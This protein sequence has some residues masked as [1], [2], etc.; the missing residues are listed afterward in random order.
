MNDESLRESIRRENAMLRESAHGGLLRR[1]GSGARLPVDTTRDEGGESWLMTYLDLMTL[2]LVLF[3][4][5]LAYAD[6]GGE[7]Y[8][9]ITR[10]MS[11]AARHGEQLIE[12]ILLEPAP[13]APIP[14]PVEEPGD[15]R[16]DELADTVLEGMQQDLLSQFSEAGMDS[17][18]EMM[19]REGQLDIQLSEQIL[20]AS[21]EARLRPEASRALTPIA[22]VLRQ[23]PYDLTVEGHT[24]NI[25]IATP[26]FP[27]NW[28][29]SASRASY[30]V[31]FLIDQGIN[32]ERLR[33]VGYADTR[34][35]GENATAEGRAKNRRVTLV[36]HQ[37]HQQDPP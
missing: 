33:A 5:L 31:R 6:R 27:S 26:L 15:P 9:Q 24:D 23:Q 36:I 12:P 34:P 30:V 22:D 28:E 7:A 29:L 32:A 3:V 17:G 35:I 4:L 13:G 14:I 11:E 21:G 37:Q 1:L 19:L 16:F 20:F 10:S 2:L 8:E 18:V 25:P